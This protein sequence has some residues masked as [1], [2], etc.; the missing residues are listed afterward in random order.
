MDGG[1]RPVAIN[2]TAT[3]ILGE[4]DGLFISADELRGSTSAVTNQLRAALKSAVCVT[5]GLSLTVRS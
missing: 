1:L 4:N 3:A 2:R 5:A